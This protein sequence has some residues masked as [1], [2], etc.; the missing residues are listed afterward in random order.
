MAKALMTLA[1]LLGAILFAPARILSGAVFPTLGNIG[2]RLVF[3][4]FLT[5]TTVALTGLVL[6]LAPPLGEAANWG[7]KIIGTSDTTTGRATETCITWN[8]QWRLLRPV[9]TEAE[10]RAITSSNG[11]IDPYVRY[12]QLTSRIE[13]EFIFPMAK[14]IRYGHGPYE[15]HPL[16]TYTLD[17]DRWR[18]AQDDFQRLYS[19]ATKHEYVFDV[20]IYEHHV[21]DLSSVNQPQWAQIKAE[22][23][24]SNDSGERWHPDRI[25]VTPIIRKFFRRVHSTR[26]QSWDHIELGW[27]AQLHG[28]DHRNTTQWHHT[29]VLPLR[30]TVDAMHK[31]ME[32][33]KSGNTW[34]P[35]KS[36]Y[37]Y[38]TSG[39]AW[40]ATP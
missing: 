36:G 25:V 22:V 19:S 15:E 13:A 33:A 27:I 11:S 10:K 5:L 31:L 29:M 38:R 14:A 8:E 3:R 40:W 17:G 28:G 1:A 30:S 34:L 21:S 7:R 39:N 4:N 6:G 32:C 35:N 23:K 20:F 2:R 26:T 16:R 37:D 9:E 24:L 12:P 18:L